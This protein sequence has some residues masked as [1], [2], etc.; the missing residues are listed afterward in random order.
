M[1]Y[2][3]FCFVSTRLTWRQYEQIA[4]NGNEHYWQDS[5]QCLEDSDCMTRKKGRSRVNAKQKTMAKFKRGL[6]PKDITQISI[7]HKL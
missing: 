5:C 2:C 6:Y 3:E 1:K 7:P 4:I